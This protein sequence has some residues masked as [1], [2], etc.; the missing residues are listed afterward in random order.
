MS[1]MQVEISCIF[2]TDFYVFSMALFCFETKLNNRTNLTLMKES[3]VED[4]ALDRLT[5][6]LHR[7]DVRER[8]YDHFDECRLLA[9]NC[10]AQGRL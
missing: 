9:T 6:G 2:F 8:F 5:A 10:L 7:V 3:S 4:H 1:K